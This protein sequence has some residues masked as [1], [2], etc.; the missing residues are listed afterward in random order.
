MGLSCCRVEVGIGDWVCV[1]LGVWGDGLGALAED[2]GADT[3]AGAALFDAN[4]EVVG[5]A[6]GELRE[7]GVGPLGFVAEAAE[8][9]EVGAGGFAVLGPRGDGHEAYGVDEFEVIDGGEQKREFFG[10]EAVLGFFVA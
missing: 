6:H 1:G 9:A 2:G 10:G 7:A 8:F 3:D 5:H 4:G